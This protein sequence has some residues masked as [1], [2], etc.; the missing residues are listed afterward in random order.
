MHCLEIVTICIELFRNSTSEILDE[1]HVLCFLYIRTACV[2][3]EV[4]LV[5]GFGPIVSS[6]RVE[7]CIK[8]TWATACADRWS[9]MDAEVVCRQLGHLVS[10][11]YI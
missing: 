6:G 1:I 5:D 4:R 10:G 11:R 3:G 2:D 9:L 7:I 8:Q